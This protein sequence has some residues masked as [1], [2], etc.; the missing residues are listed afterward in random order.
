MS[1]ALPGDSIE[2]GLLIFSPDSKCEGFN[3][4]PFPETEPS[5]NLS[6]LTPEGPL[7]CT[8]RISHKY[9]ASRPST[10]NNSTRP[11]SPTPTR[12]K[13]I[14]ESPLL[15]RLLRQ[16]GATLTPDLPL[17]TDFT[18]GRSCDFTLTVDRA[19]LSVN[20]MPM[21][22]DYG[23][24]AGEPTVDQITFF[25][26]SLKGKHVTLHASAKGSFAR[27]LTGY[28]TAW[29]MSVTHVSPDGVVDGLGELQTQPSVPSIPMCV[30]ESNG[31]TRSCP[32]PSF[33]FIDDDVEVLKERL[34]A[35][36]AEH[37]LRKRPSLAS[38]HRPRSSPQITRAMGGNAQ[39]MSS[40]NSSV[41]VV[42]FTGLANYKTIKDVVQSVVSS[43]AGSTVPLPEVMIIPKPAG[44]RR[45]L[46]AL[47]TA[48]TK[49]SLDPF[50]LPIA[51]SPTSPDVC[52]NSPFFYSYHNTPNGSPKTSGKPIRPAGSRSNSD[53]ST[54]SS[55]DI[56][57]YVSHCPP[58]PLGMSDNVE[59]F[60][61]T[62][63][64]LG[65][66]PSSGLVIQSPNG[67]PAGIFFHPRSKILR[68]PPTHSMERDKGQ[69]FVPSDRKRSS[70]KLGIDGGE[71]SV[72]FSSLHAVA[73]PPKPT[74]EPARKACLA[75]AEERPPVSSSSPII[76]RKSMPTDALR[77]PSAP[78]APPV[79]N[80]KPTGKRAPQRKSGQDNHPSPLIPSQKAKTT[81]DGNIVPP[82]SVL[83]VDGQLYFFF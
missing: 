3:V 49:P 53:R 7:S 42:H 50:F 54:K 30:S 43:H 44:P 31:A 21:I 83:I 36:R 20:N 82:I 61:E 14:F 70:S 64:K 12:K 26:E 24:E 23:D 58:S 5:T 22:N 35:M 72:T 10:A 68:N 60:G 52:H 69:L 71:P 59:Y 66:S 46:T 78:V 47:Y 15:R 6:P 76:T 29:G 75:K 80:N 33:V 77:K 1:T 37:H 34:Q 2:L 79:E 57:D 45:F 67:Q 11:V 62:A 56:L 17:T 81:T 55:K 65:A 51:T 28:L 40:S 41:V 48:A 63:T 13:L 27:H 16:V 8:I 32:P 9:R 25:T 4:S 38:Y 74:V 19:S 39:S 73:G 18:D